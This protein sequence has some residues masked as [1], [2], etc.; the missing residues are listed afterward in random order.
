MPGAV[1]ANHLH[2]HSLADARHL[3][4]DAAQADHAQCLAEKLNSF[5]RCPNAATD[6]AIHARKIARA[7]PQQRYCMLRHCR[8]AVALD[9]M[10]LDPTVIELSDIHVACRSCAQENDMFELRALRYQRSR[11]V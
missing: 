5:M 11:H 9:D 2:A 8:I 6:L 7:S 10:H 1:P 4:S 3:A